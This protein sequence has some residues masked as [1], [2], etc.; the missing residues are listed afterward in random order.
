M[1]E[2]EESCCPKKSAPA[3]PN[4]YDALGKDLKQGNTDLYVVGSG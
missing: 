4:N 1:K 3:S 2:E